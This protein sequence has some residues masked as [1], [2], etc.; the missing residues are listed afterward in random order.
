MIY[1]EPTIYPINAGGGDAEVMGCTFFAAVVAV[2][3]AFIW[4][5][6]AVYGAAIAGW[7]AVS[8]VWAGAAVYYAT[9][10]GGC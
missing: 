4:G 10:G 8:A 5:G 6:V 3:G 7:A 1:E 9:V 2:A